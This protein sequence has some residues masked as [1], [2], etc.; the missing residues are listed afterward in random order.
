MKKKP[1]LIIPIET[2]VREFDAKLL[3]A[4]VALRQGFDVVIGALWEL[5]FHTD[6]LDRGIFLDKSIAKTKQQWFRCCRRQ[7]HRVAAL[8]EEG[9]VYFDAETYRQLRIFPKSMEAADLFFAWGKDQAEVTAPAIGRLSERV[10]ITGNPRFDLLRPALRRLYEEDVVRLRKQY[11]RIIQIN[12]S[13]SFANSANDPKALLRTFSQY[14][15]AEERPGFFEGWM[16]VQQKVLESF[17]E[18]LPRIRKRFPEHT[19]IIRPHPSEGL[20]L[21]QELANTLDKTTVIREGNVVPWILASD[22]LVH[23]N[24]T[25]AIEALLLGKPAIAYRKEQS[26]S[27]EQPLPNACSF[28]ATGIDEL[29]EMLD[30]AL[31]ENLIHAKEEISK[32]FEIL[33]HHISSLQGSF[34]SEKMVE[35]LLQLSRSFERQRN[36]PQQ[37]IQMLKR[38]WRAVLDQVDSSR[39]IRDQYIAGKFPDT[40]VEEVEERVLLLKEC[41]DY[42]DNVTVR[43]ECRNCFFLSAA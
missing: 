27:Y 4:I 11:G 41:I 30:L 22:V 19:I 31:Q 2:K 1:L 39:H 21:W 26:D 32:Q 3:L 29:L 10:R 40:T 25:T 33:Q 5:K 35:E 12:T 42:N 9:L 24:C 8:D 6:L 17:R 23:W 37:S 18:M 28:H 20:E 43:K 16:A 15:I 14:P 13:F 38:L 36:I 34:A 7:G